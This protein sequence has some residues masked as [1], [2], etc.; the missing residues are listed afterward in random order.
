MT[1]EVGQATTSAVALP[2]S[3]RSST[4]LNGLLKAAPRPSKYIQPGD[5]V[6]IFMSRDKPP[7][8]ITVTSGHESSNTYGS[9]LHDS[10]I[11]LPFGA[12][13]CVR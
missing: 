1:T 2:A 6:I 5:L 8:P 10:M 4:T 12:K 3:A 11:G 9:F 13:V 7:I